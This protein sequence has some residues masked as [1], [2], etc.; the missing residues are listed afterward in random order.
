MARA[1]AYQATYGEEHSSDVRCELC[2]QHR[3]PQG[4]DEDK[5]RPAQVLLRVGLMLQENLSATDIVF[6]RYLFNLT[7]DQLG[8][9]HGGKS[10]QAIEQDMDRI[11]A[12]YPEM[13]AG[14]RRMQPH[15]G[16]GD[17]LHDD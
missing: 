12:L 2:G 13:V 7:Y 11:C 17:G 4:Q 1:V 16:N 9:R 8:Q 14:L 6:M 10:R 15:N 3:E 5:Y